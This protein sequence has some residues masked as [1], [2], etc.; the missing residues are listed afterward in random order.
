[1]KKSGSITLQTFVYRTLTIRLAAWAIVIGLLSTGVAFTIE[2]QHL[3]SI[4]VEVVRAEIQLLV[5]RTEEIIKE[6]G[7]EKLAAFRQALDERSSVE[8]DFQRRSGTY[9]YA[10]FY[11][12]ED[13]SIEERMDSR[14][15]LI[16]PVI[17]LIRAMPRPDNE[18]GESAEVVMLGKRMHVHLL[19]PVFNQQRQSVGYAQAIFAPSAAARIDVRNRLLRTVLLAV[20][21]VLTTSGLLYPVILQLV[22]KLTVFSHDLLHAN[23]ETLSILASAIAKRDSDT[24]AHNFRVTLYAVR[25]AESLRLENREIQSLIKGAFLHDIGKIGIS[26]TILLKPGALNE[27]EF[28]LM[29]DHVRYGME[30]IK[31]STWLHDAAAVVAA[32]HEKFDGSGYPRGL[33][34][35]GIPMLARIFAIVDVFDALTSQRPYKKPLSFQ[36]TMSILRQG[37]GSHFDPEVLGIFEDIAPELYRVYARRDDQEL[38]TELQAVISRYFSREEILYWNQGSNKQNI[39]ENVSGRGMQ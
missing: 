32:H 13:D 12:L 36:E 18:A 2:Q 39:A 27:D 22:N 1:M 9:V 15:D 30:I 7:K 29:K 23:L 35:A 16:D 37:L 14:Y 31:D 38:R 8:T 34:G 28:A 10:S 11:S 4:F 6:Q 3:R 24:D 21:I 25:L 5:L 20:T 17:R 33:A 19:L 26:D